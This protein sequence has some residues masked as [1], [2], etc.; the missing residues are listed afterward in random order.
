MYRAGQHKLRLLLMHF[1]ETCT[2]SWTQL[3]HQNQAMIGI[4]KDV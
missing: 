2:L 4:K 1:I 3:K